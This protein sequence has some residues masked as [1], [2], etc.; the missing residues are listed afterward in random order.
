MWLSGDTFQINKT[1]FQWLRWI[2]CPPGAQTEKLLPSVPAA[3]GESASTD[4][5]NDVLIRIIERIYVQCFENLQ[6]REVKQ[7]YGRCF[8]NRWPRGPEQIAA[9]PPLRLSVCGHSATRSTRCKRCKGRNK[10]TEGRR[11]EEGGYVINIQER[12]VCVCVFVW[13]T[14]GETLGTLHPFVVGTNKTLNLI[15]QRH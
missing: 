3:H 14:T 12:R 15:K 4:S 1:L 5:I 2:V 10:H 11:G 9:D 8:L 13:Q 7:E 6:Q